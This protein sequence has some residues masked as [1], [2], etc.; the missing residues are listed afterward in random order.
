MQPNQL[1]GL[2]QKTLKGYIWSQRRYLRYYLFWRIV[3]VLVITPFPILTQWIVDIAIQNQDMEALMLF[4]GMFVAL[5][6][7]HYL[8]MHL[9]VKDISPRS[10]EILRRLRGRLFHKLNFMHFGFLDSTQTGRLLSKYAF[11]T[12]NIEMVMVMT[13][14]NIIPELLRSVLLII[15]LSVINI[16]LL[17]IVLISLPIFAF[18]RLH[19][20]KLLESTNHDVRVARE[21]MTGQASEFISAIKLVRGYGQ[22][23]EAKRQLGEL[24]DA[25]SYSRESQMNIN[26]QM[27]YVNFTIVT[28]LTIFATVFC[29]WLVIVGKMTVGEMMAL[30]GALTV[31][32]QPVNIITQ[33]SMQYMQG[34]E[35]YRSIKE[36]IDSGYVEKWQGKEIIDPFRGEVAF[37]SVTFSY[38]EEKDPVIRDFSIKI[39]SGEHVA[40]VG[41][42]GS[43]KST[44]VSLML[45]FYAP[46]IGEIRVDGV[47][48][49]QLAIRVFRQ[50]CAI[51]MQDNLLL[52]GS[53]LDNIR[54][55]KPNATMDEVFE[56]AKNANALEFIEQLPEG[57]QTKVGERGVSL[58]GGQRQRIAIAR[59]LLR[60]PK[61]LILD[62]ATSALDYESEKTVQEAI[63]R[64]A[65]GRTT[66]TIAHRLSTI[67]AADRIVVLQNGSI[68]SQGSW[69]E[70][71]EQ[72][73]AFKDLL[74]AQS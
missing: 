43:G 53:L 26:Q 31:C 37:D 48:Q 55:G 28:G 49:E 44:L 58:S 2:H 74:D 14:A 4:G 9:A 8:A 12:N 69:D 19:Y 38:D 11:D 15:A 65:K 18:V 71:A 39:Q 45:G 32:L 16:W 17:L 59:A 41:P 33:F 42:S 66:I 56:A 34:A 62:E 29:G 51:V 68:V 57:F 67:R 73:G 7:L 10:Q 35:S 61:I 46:T 40:F 23:Q 52:S 60:D 13:V 1:L 70:L 63:D 47:P 64:L 21:K 36:L 3:S 22:E 72:E 6:A 5:L 30:L 20:I 27:G 25:Y 54:F 24:S 50:T